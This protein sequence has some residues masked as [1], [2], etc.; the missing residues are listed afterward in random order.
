MSNAAAIEAL[1]EEI[2]HLAS[3]VDALREEDAPPA[4]SGRFVKFDLE[5]RLVYAEVY[6]PDVEDA[7]GHQMTRAEIEKMAHGFMKAQRTNMID[8]QHDNQTDYGC[9]MV[10]SFIARD[11]DPDYVPGSWVACVKVENDEI[12]KAIKSG[13]LTGFSFEGLGFV[14]ETPT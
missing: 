2:T 8:V 12:W 3:K 1:K 5:K 14:S 13:E 9:Y 11:S 4:Q 6:L 7:H 10:E